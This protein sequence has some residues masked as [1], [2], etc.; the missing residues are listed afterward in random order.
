MRKKRSNGYRAAESLMREEFLKEQLYKWER[1][2]SER[3][4][5]LL[6]AM[7]PDEKAALC[8]LNIDGETSEIKR[9]DIPSVRISCGDEILPEFPD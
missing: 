1:V 8:S 5:S 4:N 3:L 9:L 2:S 6:A 7:S